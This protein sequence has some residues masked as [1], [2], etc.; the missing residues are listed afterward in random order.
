M[1]KRVG[2]DCGSVG[3]ARGEQGGKIGITVIEK[4]KMA[5]ALKGK[6]NEFKNCFKQ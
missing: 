3:G 4:Q 5:E 2:I 1:D 6:I